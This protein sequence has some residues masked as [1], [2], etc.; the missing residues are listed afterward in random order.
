[1]LRSIRLIDLQHCVW[2]V[3]SQTAAGNRRPKEK[4]ERLELNGTR[5]LVFAGSVNLLGENINIV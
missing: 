2:A 4:V 5:L 1:M 3:F